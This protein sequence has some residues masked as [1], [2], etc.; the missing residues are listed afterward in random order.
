MKGFQ[1]VTGDISVG[2]TFIFCPSEMPSPSKLIL[3]TRK[4]TVLPLFT[5]AVTMPAEQFF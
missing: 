2:S 1:K 4:N 5:P 3:P